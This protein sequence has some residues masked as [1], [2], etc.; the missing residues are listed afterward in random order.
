MNC[1]IRNESLLSTVEETFSNTSNDNFNETQFSFSNEILNNPNVEEIVNIINKSGSNFLLNLH[2]S[3]NFNR[4]D[5]SRIGD[6]IKSEITEPIV[7]TL[8][9][10]YDVNRSSIN[11]D[12]QFNTILKTLKI[13]SQIVIP[14]IN[15]TIG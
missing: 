1:K 10:F 14:H 5:V 12:E 7:K 3:N 2:N 13:P 11:F 9:R 6:M 4:K 8:T 15:F